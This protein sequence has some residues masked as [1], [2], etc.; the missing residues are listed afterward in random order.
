LFVG[1]AGS[2]EQ[3]EDLFR[4]ASD[5]GLEDLVSKHHERAGRSPNWVKV[6]NPKHPA[7]TRVKNTF[8]ALEL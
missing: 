6:K 1:F 7:T 2:F 4:K 8:G 5:F 3:G